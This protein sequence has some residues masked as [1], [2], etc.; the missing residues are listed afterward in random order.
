M[1][2]HGVPQDLRHDERT[3]VDRLR[4]PV[5]TV[6]LVLTLLA[7]GGP[8]QAIVVACG[9]DERTV[10]V[11]GTCRPPGAS[12]AEHLVEQPRDL[13]HVQADAIRVQTQGGS[14][15]WRWR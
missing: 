12:R 11:G 7:H 5:E 14:S 15:G 8:Q 9:F 13:G 3:A 1:H 6:A 4:T 10:G 2:S